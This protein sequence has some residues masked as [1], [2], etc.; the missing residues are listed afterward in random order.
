MSKKHHTKEAQIKASIPIIYIQHHDVVLASHVG[1]TADEQEMADTLRWTREPSPP[2]RLTP[3]ATSPVTA[4]C[5][6]D[7]GLFFSWTFPDRPAK[8]HRASLT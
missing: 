5:H 3:L 7:A 4:D 8:G 2:N 6:Y 1:A